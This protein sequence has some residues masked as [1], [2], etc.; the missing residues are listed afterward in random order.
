MAV[1]PVYQYPFWN[2]YNVISIDCGIQRP[3]LAKRAKTKI[4][5]ERTYSI[6]VSFI[7]LPLE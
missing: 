2:W 7:Q 3:D 1:R 4:L 5:H 6:N